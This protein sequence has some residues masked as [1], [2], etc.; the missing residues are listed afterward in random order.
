MSGDDKPF[1][2]TAMSR[3][4]S[5]LLGRPAH[6]STSAR[7]YSTWRVDEVLPGHGGRGEQLHLEISYGRD[8]M[9]VATIFGIRPRP[10]ALPGSVI[11]EAISN[12]AQA[13]HLPPLDTNP[14]AVAIGNVLR[15]AV[16]RAHRCWRRERWAR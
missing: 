7:A 9:I 4:L 15:A 5:S 11:A 16:A 1:P 10:Y 12:L 14:V 3:E 13:I 2:D 6:A 8:G